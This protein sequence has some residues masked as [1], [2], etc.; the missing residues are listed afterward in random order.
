VDI[1]SLPHPGPQPN[2]PGG[3]GAPVAPA[4]DVFAGSQPQIE[5]IG[6]PEMPSDLEVTQQKGTNVM[7]VSFASAAGVFFGLYAYV[8]PL[9]L[10]TSWVVLALL[11]LS[12]REDLSRGGTIA[13]MAAILVVPF[14]GVVAYYI[15]GKST[16]PAWQRWVF[17]AGGVAVY[18]L[19]LGLGMVIGGIV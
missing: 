13:W 12:R 11:D 4:V 6:V 3:A 19:F 16:I 8:L 10:Y 7:G 14:L 18:L 2:M 5:G 9:V 15:L 1:A 17:I